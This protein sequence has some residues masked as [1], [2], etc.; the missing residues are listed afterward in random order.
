MDN[1]PMV[2]PS[3]C[4]MCEAKN[5]RI[6]ALE[7]ELAEALEA[8]DRRIKEARNAEK[9]AVNKLVELRRELAEARRDGER[10]DW[11]IRNHEIVNTDG[12]YD[13][14]DKDALDDDE[15]AESLKAW[16]KYLDEEIDAARGGGR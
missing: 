16:R 2:H 14:A 3:R 15:D 11:L 10:L 6:E 9:K 1:M 8:G 7:R 12:W 5:S 13:H 4:R